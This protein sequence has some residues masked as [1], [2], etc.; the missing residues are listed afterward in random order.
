MPTPPILLFFFLVQF[1]RR[2]IN[3]NLTCISIEALFSLYNQIQ[4]FWNHTDVVYR[5]G[6]IHNSFNKFGTYESPSITASFD[7][8]LVSICAL[9]DFNYSC[10]THGGMPLITFL[11]TPRVSNFSHDCTLPWKRRLSRRDCSL[12]IYGIFPSQYQKIPSL[13]HEVATYF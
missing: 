3:F 13:Y 8:P 6:I 2:N 7:V 1:M 5:C 12:C 4:L 9:F 10:V 11:V